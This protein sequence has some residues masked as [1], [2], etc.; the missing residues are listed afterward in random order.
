MNPAPLDTFGS[1]ITRGKVYSV[2]QCRGPISHRQELAAELK[3]ICY[4]EQHLNS[5]TNTR[6]N[7]GF[8]IGPNLSAAGRTWADLYLKAVAEAFGVNTKGVV[9]SG[10]GASLVARVPWPTP[11]LVLEPLFLSAKP[12]LNAKGEEVGVD[13]AEI[14]Q[15]PEA[16]ELLGMCLAQ[17]IVRAFP[18]GGLVALSV[19]HA[20]RLPSKGVSQGDPGALYP[21][22]DPLEPAWDP[23]Y[24]T[25]AEVA[26]SAIAY[27]TEHLVSF[28]TLERRA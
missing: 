18:K 17:S 14:M 21:K 1:F 11:A 20:Y 26:D 10:R 3:A 19:G 16:R 5:S 22:Q 2:L 15:T 6:V 8:V 27:A 9:K 7:H 23:A 4:A 28:A 13:V 25:E 24:D 12:Y